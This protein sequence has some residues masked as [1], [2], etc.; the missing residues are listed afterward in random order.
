MRSLIGKNVKVAF[1]GASHAESVGCIIDGM[2]PGVKADADF[3]RACLDRRRPGGEL[4][5]PRREEDIPIVDGG[6]KDGY[7]TGE[8]ITVRFMNTDVRREDYKNANTI[9]RPSHAD[10][11][12][13]LRY[14]FIPSGGGHFS[15]R[16]TAP[17]VFAGA[18][19]RCALAER[20]IVVGAHLLRVG[21]A[22]DAPFDLLKVSKADLDALAKREFPT[23][24]KCAEDEMK[25]IISEAAREGDSVGG[26]IECAAV[27]MA[28]GYGTHM[29]R[30][31]EGTISSYLFAI[32]ALKSVEFGAGAEFAA[33]RGSYA[34][35]EDEFDEEGAVKLLSNNCGGAVGGMTTGAP[36]VF[37]CAF[38]PTPSIA[39]PQRSVDLEKRENVTLTIGGRHDPCC[40]LRAIEAVNSA[41]ALALL[42][43]CYDPK[44]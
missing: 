1:F 41:C 9:P 43:L 42:D 18:L 26:M 38:K 24:D 20:G 5:S 32:P 2:R 15:G 13:Y 44:G 21:E 31:V 33:M 39:L 37:R 6:I 28:A 23:I 8:R 4:A 36:I 25:K 34:N 27:G 16:M 40:A 29:F 3:I 19:A 11:P 14:G 12:A 10:Y 22:I 7:T 35:D 30:S 17:L